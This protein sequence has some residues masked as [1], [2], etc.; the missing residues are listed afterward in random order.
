MRNSS[1]G[2]FAAL[3][4]ETR[5]RIVARLSTDGPMSIRRLTDGSKIT[6]QAISKHLQVMATAR[7]VRCRRRGRESLW[8]LDPRRLEAAR[9]YLDAISRQ[10]D[11]ALL[12]LRSLVED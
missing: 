4:D 10:W 9:H 6:R 5:L 11:A 3:G 1:A 2:L 8:E 7:L 12:R